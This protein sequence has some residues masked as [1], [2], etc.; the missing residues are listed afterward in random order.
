MVFI[1]LAAC[2]TVGV[3]YVHRSIWLGF[4]IAQARYS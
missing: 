4:A 3:N 1:L 2:I